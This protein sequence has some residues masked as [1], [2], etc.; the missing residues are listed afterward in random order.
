VTLSKS[1][2]AWQVYEVKTL[3]R[4][5]AVSPGKLEERK[6]IVPAEKK[7]HGGIP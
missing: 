2:K 3:F 5:T 4:A 7:I 1:H 6:T